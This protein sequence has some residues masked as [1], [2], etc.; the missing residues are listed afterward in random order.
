[1]V[2]GSGQTPGLGLE[3]VH[4]A[5]SHLRLEFTFEPHHALVGDPMAEEPGRPLSLCQALGGLGLQP[6]LA[7]FLTQHLEGCAAPCS[8]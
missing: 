5:A 4:Q 3:A 7:T 2:G 8:L 6:P 1:V